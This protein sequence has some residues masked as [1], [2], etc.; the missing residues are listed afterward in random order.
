MK[1]RLL[2][3]NEGFS[4]VELIVVIAIILVFSTAGLISVSLI[5]NGKAKDAGMS[6]NAEVSTILSRGKSENVILTDDLKKT[7]GSNVDASTLDTKDCRFALR[8]YKD[9][10]GKY[11]VQNGFIH[12]G[13]GNT[14]T[15]IYSE[16]ANKSGG[17]GRCLTGNIVIKLDDTEITA[18]N[19]V[20]I[21]FSRDGSCKSGYGTYKF[22]LKSGKVSSTIVINKNGTRQTK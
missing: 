20:I 14:E 4:L 21:R 1:K 15:F 3:N 19:P 13:A 5:N 7:D 10:D 22:C 11:Y 18:S 6:F 17:K 12:Y 16:S 9:S 8:L 2:K